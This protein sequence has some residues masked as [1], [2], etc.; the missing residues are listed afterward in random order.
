M[1]LKIIVGPDK[2]IHDGLTIRYW[3]VTMYK[4]NNIIT[5]RQYLHAVVLRRRSNGEEMIFVG[6]AR[7]EYR[8]VVPAHIYQ[9]C[10]STKRLLLL[11]L[12]SSRWESVCGR[13]SADQSNR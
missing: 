10:R 5:V 7:A 11:L 12:L 1:V 4:Y 8:R 9:V 13:K 6:Y 3:H 2:N